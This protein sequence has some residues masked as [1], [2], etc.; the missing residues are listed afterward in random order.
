M[1]KGTP[2]TRGNRP[3]GI[4]VARFRNLESRH[5]EFLR[6]YGFQGSAYQSKW[7]HAFAMPGFGA[8]FKR[9]VKQERPWNIGLGGFGECLPYFENFCELDRERVDAWGIPVLHI[10]MAFGENERKMVQDMADTAEE[11]LRAAGADDIKREAEISKPGLAIHEVGT[12]RM[13]NDP[14]TSVLNRWQQAHDVSNLFVMDG[15]C[16]PASAC[17]NP[18]ITLMALASRSCDRLVEEY[19]AGRV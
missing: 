19:L 2:D 1:L 8:D 13:G 11:M 15:S 7:G 10:S 3:N 5:P 14:K 12:A 16:Y 4:Y 9:A 18:T 6:G 17:Q